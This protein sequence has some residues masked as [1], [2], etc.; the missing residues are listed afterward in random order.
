M[1]GV[2]GFEPTVHEIKIRGYYYQE[3][4]RILLILYNS[5]ILSHASYALSGKSQKLL[6]KLLSKN[7][8]LI[9]DEE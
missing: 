4:L 3:L 5:S 7:I 1:A 8:F 2:V 9:Y 6:S